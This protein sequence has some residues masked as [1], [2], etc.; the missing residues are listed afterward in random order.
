MLH[1]LD[2]SPVRCRCSPLFTRSFSVHFYPTEPQTSPSSPPLIFLLHVPSSSLTPIHCPHPRSPPLN[3]STSPALH[4]LISMSCPSF[5]RG[6]LTLPSCLQ[7]SSLHLHSQHF[8]SAVLCRH[9]HTHTKPQNIHFSVSE[10]HFTVCLV[11]RIFTPLARERVIPPPP[12]HEIEAFTAHTR[13]PAMCE[14][15]NETTAKSILW[16]RR[17]H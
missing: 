13:L 9:T 4:L 1:F 17:P 14:L 8:R 15:R 16:G 7:H 2:D 10:P 12:L 11:T 3:P 5:R 6:C